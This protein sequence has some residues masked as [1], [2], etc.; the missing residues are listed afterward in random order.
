AAVHG[1]CYTG[2]LELALGADLIVAAES[3][4]FADTHGKWG[5]APTW[6]MSQ[7]LPRRIGEARAK[8]MMLTG[9]VVSGQ[10]AV[11]IGLAHAC[12][13]DQAFEAELLALARS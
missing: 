8:G 13:P 5:M 10:E 12:F 3:A 6:G 1:H 7:R 9:R 2:A 4:R 11:A